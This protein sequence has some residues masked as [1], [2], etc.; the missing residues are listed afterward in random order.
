V[1]KNLL[2][3]AVLFVASTAIA[4]GAAELVLRIK[5]SSMK[6]YDIEMWRYAKEL[7]IPSQDSSLGHEHV[8]NASALLQS[9]DISS[10]LKNPLAT[11]C[12]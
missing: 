10:L 5:N 1:N 3:S 8:K 7:K 11:D 6:N 2:Y 12:D 4:L 9:V